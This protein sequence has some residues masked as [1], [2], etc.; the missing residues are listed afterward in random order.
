M[1]FLGLVPS[2]ARLV[3]WCQGSTFVPVK[4]RVIRAIVFI[5]QGGSVFLH[6]DF[7]VDGRMIFTPDVGQEH[8]LRDSGIVPYCIYAPSS[9]CLVLHV[10][11]ARPLEED[12]NIALSDK[13]SRVLTGKLKIDS[14]LSD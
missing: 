1:P 11:R 4:A 10:R 9:G 2:L 14:P 6:F 12:G 13:K 3:A 8:H 5:L 7:L